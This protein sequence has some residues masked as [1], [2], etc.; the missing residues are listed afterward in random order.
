MKAYFD[1]FSGI[2]GN[3][4]IGALI[5]LGMQI[6]TLRNELKKLA[7]AGYEIDAERVQRG[8]IEAVHFKVTVSDSTTHRRL[9]DILD[10]LNQSELDDDI[11]TGCRKIFTLLAHSE[12]KVHG[13]SP[14]DIVFHELSGVDTLVDV[15]GSLTGLKMLGVSEV[16]ASPINLGSGT[17]E[18]AHG[19]LPIPAPGTAEILKGVPAYTRYDGELTTP[20]GAA[21]IATLAARFGDMPLMRL[22]KIGCGAGSRNPSH[23]NILRIFLGTSAETLKDFETQTVCHI[24]TNIDDL[25]PQVYGYLFERMLMSGALDVFLTPVIMK[26]GRPGTLLNVLCEEP[27][28]PQIVEII[29]KETTTLGMR[30]QRTE[31]VK[32][33]R[34]VEMVETRFGIIRVKIALRD[35]RIENISPEYEDCANAARKTGVS[36]LEVMRETSEEAHRRFPIGSQLKN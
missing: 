31:R 22:E 29:L 27:Q 23:P 3:M 21:I 14:E 34:Q 11:R 36:L 32:L 24:Q 28:V 19:I 16:A 2:S 8:G 17:I 18:C 15:V 6:S 4:I 33:P 25:S 1:C 26:K 9:K 20:T 13:K 5:D 10:I 12:A 35:G 30:L 7:I